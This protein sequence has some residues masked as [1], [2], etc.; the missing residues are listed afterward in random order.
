MPARIL[1]VEDNHAN[2]ELVAYLLQAHGHSTLSAWNGAE[3]LRLIRDAAPDLVLCDLQMPVMSGYELIE[4]LRR[5]PSRP[6]MPIIAV[7]AASMVGDA[8]SALACGFDAYI[9]KPIEP[10]T[11]I[12]GIEQLLPPALRASVPR[13]L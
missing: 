4:Q 3:G 5:D 10:E 9:A 12:S 7:S 11:F 1:I 2:H 6:Q 8:A 13:D